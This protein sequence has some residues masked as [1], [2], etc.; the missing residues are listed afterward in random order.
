[1]IKNSVINIS[2]DIAT[3]NAVR[4]LYS[5]YGM[6]VSDA[7][8]I[9]FNKSLKKKGFPFKVDQPKYNKETLEAFKEVEEIKKNPHLYKSYDTFQELLDD[10]D[11]EDEV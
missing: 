11:S 3:E 10:L 2:T 5:E 7:V 9:F 4:S 6:S 1:M 8:N